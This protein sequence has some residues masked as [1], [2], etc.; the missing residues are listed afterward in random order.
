MFTDP[1]RMA[2]IGQKTKMQFSLKTFRGG[3]FCRGFYK[4]KVEELTENGVCDKMNLSL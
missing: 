3:L 4:E 2:K 1:K